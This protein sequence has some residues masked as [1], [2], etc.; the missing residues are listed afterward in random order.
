AALLFFA[1]VINYIDRQTLSVLAVQISDELGLSNIEYAQ[2]LQAFLI[3]YAAMYIVWGVLIDRWGT[4]V[5]LAVA[6]IWW[7]LANMLHAGARGAFSLGM[8]RALLG[9][10]EAGNFLAA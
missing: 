1:T 3:C 10:G 6:M 9:A 7:S 8:L 2:I 5:A 4:R